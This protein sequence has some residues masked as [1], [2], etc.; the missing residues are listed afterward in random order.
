MNDSYIQLCLNIVNKVFIA[1]IITLLISG[2]SLFLPI[3]EYIK[4]KSK[5]AKTPFGFIYKLTEEVIDELLHPIDCRLCTG[6]YISFI[7]CAN[8]LS[9]WLLVWG[10]SYF[11]AT[12]ERD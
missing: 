5:W 8:N 10:M 4:S 6:A 11:L 9:Y 2:S 3:R 12:L 1:Y 7:V